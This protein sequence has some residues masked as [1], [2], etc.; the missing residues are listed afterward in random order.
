M[1]RVGVPCFADKM[2]W[3][4][5]RECGFFILLLNLLALALLL[6]NEVGNLI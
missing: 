5:L 6:L 2:S 3:F 1:A 4:F